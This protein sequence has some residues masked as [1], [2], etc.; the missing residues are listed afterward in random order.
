MAG[1][2]FLSDYLDGSSVREVIAI[3]MLE[4]Q[5]L[6]NLTDDFV[7]SLPKFDDGIVRIG[8]R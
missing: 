2:H 4:D 7:F 3:G 5:A 6:C 1:V 8:D